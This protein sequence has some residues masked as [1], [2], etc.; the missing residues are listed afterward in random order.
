[1]LKDKL[2]ELK[3][4]AAEKI[5]PETFAIMRNSIQA[6]AASGVMERAPQVGDKIEDFTLPDAN[7]QEVQLA[8]LRHKGPVIISSYRGVW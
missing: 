7:G 6:V 8:E 4:A 2:A 5:P 3:A 1:M